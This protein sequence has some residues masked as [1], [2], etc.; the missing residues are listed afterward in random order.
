MKKIYSLI[1]LLIVPVM[2]ISLA[3]P[4]KAHAEQANGAM[5]L[6]I[7]FI[8][9]A[10]G[11]MNTSDPDNI[12]KDAVDLML[13]LCDPAS[14]R[15]GVVMFSHEEEF[16]EKNHFDLCELSNSNKDS[17]KHF[18]SNE[19][20]DYS[21]AND[22]NLQLGLAKALEYY[23]NKKGDTQGRQP[24]FILVSDGCT[25]LGS[26]E[27]SNASNELLKNTTIP[28]YAAECIPVYTLGLYPDNSSMTKD[29]L[30][31]A[32]NLMKTI[33]SETGG[34]NLNVTS[35]GDIP[36]FFMNIFALTNNV[37]ETKINVASQSDSRLAAKFSI[38]NKSIAYTNII[39]KSTNK[40]DISVKLYHDDYT[41]TLGDSKA[42]VITDSDSLYTIIKLKSP[43]MGDYIVTFDKPGEVKADGNRIGEVEC[44]L[45]STYSTYID[46]FT[47]DKTEI[48]PGDTI[49][50]YTEVKQDN[51][52]ITDT[53]LINALNCTTFVRNTDD[54][55][56]EAY[57]ASAQSDEQAR[58]SLDIPF[59]KP[60][61]YEVFS[62]VGSDE[63]FQKQSEP[64]TVNVSNDLTGISIQQKLTNAEDGSDIVESVMRDQKIRIQ[65]FSDNDMETVLSGNKDD[66]HA[67]CFVSA[68]N[69]EGNE[70]I[71]LVFDND[72]F[73][74]EYTLTKK[75]SYS[76]TSMISLDN[77]TTPIKTDAITITTLPSAVSP[78]SSGKT[79]T[80]GK[81][82]F[83][84][85]RAACAAVKLSDYL[86]W[87]HADED[88][89]K[90][91]C[92]SPGNE[93]IFSADTPVFQSTDYI[94]NLTA[95]DIGES[96]ISFTITD[97]RNN[98]SA[99]ITIDVAV[100]GTLVYYRDCLITAVIILILLCVIIIFAMKKT[101]PV[102]DDQ[103]FTMTISHEND[104]ASE[105]EFKLIDKTYSG[106]LYDI[107][108]FNKGNINNHTLWESKFKPNY[109][110]LCITREE[111]RAISFFMDR[112]KQIFVRL[113]DTKNFS[114]K[115]SDKK[116][117][118]FNDTVVIEYS[119]N[120]VTIELTLASKK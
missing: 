46:I 8:C 109:D 98:T 74:G 25:D 103:K 89:L 105:K 42:N 4:A 92:T 22:T 24:V 82:L 45:I 56:T 48:S 111:L 38:D 64:I 68:D 107:L 90:I 63:T 102:F 7:M 21:S 11:S 106:N 62:A 80:M 67:V 50:F 31:A 17:L 75:G 108:S 72:C 70:K 84:P 49:S 37:K 88:C 27:L 34:N 83:V 58:F 19:M 23:N 1:C 77:S 6:D 13:D 2:L 104:S 5:N 40:S 44:S 55:S 69:S 47:E 110:S 79:V 118:P 61:T 60:G 59:N 9:D 78:K 95:N 57:E 116:E 94:I 53:S 101:R 12:G 52:V 86:Y 51:S 115:G 120:N 36:G 41:V 29:D 112:K 85:K 65:V 81:G 18:I 76:F 15:A 30:E 26:E 10:S 16:S 117:L 91:E 54:D 71:D 87:D 73:S 97:T 20:G 39:V 113:N 3:A 119:A 43:G 114:F 14:C 66:L 33:S 99:D 96:S 93:S 28:E 35:A 100:A 32:R